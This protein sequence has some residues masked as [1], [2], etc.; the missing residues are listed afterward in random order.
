MSEKKK[1]RHAF[2]S[3]AAEV[4][5]KRPKKKGCGWEDSTGMECGPKKKNPRKPN[6]KGRKEIKKEKG[7]VQNHRLKGGIKKKKNP[8]WQGA[9]KAKVTT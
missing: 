5:Q 2:R 1:G 6:T 9:K 8:N 4:F 3:D 7:W